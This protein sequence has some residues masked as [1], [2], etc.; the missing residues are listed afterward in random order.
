MLSGKAAP[1][2]LSGFLPSIRVGSHD[3]LNDVYGCESDCFP[4]SVARHWQFLLTLPTAPASGPNSR[5]ATP[6]E[7]VER[8][9]LGYRSVFLPASLHVRFAFLPRS[10]DRMYTESVSHPCPPRGTSG[11]TLGLYNDLSG[12]PKRAKGPDFTGG[13]ASH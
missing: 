2:T 9:R 12:I 6:N 11:I 5:G 8:N 13:L 7:S 1:E 3:L 4:N 10:V